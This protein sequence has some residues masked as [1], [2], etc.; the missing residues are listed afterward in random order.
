GMRERVKIIEQ[1]LQ[2]ADLVFEILHR[3]DDHLLARVGMVLQR[4]LEKLHGRGHAVQGIADLVGEHRRGRAD[5][6]HRLFLFQLALDALF[7]TLVAEKNAAAL[8]RSRLIA[9]R[10][11]LD[12]REQLAA[13]APAKPAAR[14]RAVAPERLLGDRLP[15][16]CAEER[17]KQRSLELAAAAAEHSRRRR[18]RINHPVLE[19]EEQNTA[20]AQAFDQTLGTKSAPAPFGARLAG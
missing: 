13:V 14:D 2:P 11:R 17:A 6:R 10:Q 1:R 7:F 15:A 4:A 18:I 9:Q 12:A 3:A 20:L 19:I 16:R 8:E 5:R